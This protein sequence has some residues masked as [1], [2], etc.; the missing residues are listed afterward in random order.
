M[1]EILTKQGRIVERLSRYNN[2]RSDRVSWPCDG[3]QCPS[4]VKSFRQSLIHMTAIY[5]SCHIKRPLR[6]Q[7][8]VFDKMPLWHHAMG[9]K[10]F[11]D[12]ILH[13]Q[14]LHKLFI[15][16]SLRFNRDEWTTDWHTA[17]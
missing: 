4:Y 7:R 9:C 6:R 10:E 12:Q 11:V 2:L 14:I 5:A 16:N 17:C 15:D 8:E 3:H 13:L 1:S